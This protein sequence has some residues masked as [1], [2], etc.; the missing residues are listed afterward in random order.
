MG[1]R[2]ASGFVD[3]LLNAPTRTVAQGRRRQP[4]KDMTLYTG[5]TYQ[6]TPRLALTGAYYS[7]AKNING[8]EGNR[9][10]RHAAVLL[11]EYSLSKRTQ[12]YGTVDFN[13]TS[14]GANAEMPGKNNQTGLG[15][16]LRH[17]F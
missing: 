14:G 10:K 5:L 1:G 12:V 8:F 3:S 13:R 7:D 2:D 9:G 11:A 6:A 4:R 15:V 16:G 17:I